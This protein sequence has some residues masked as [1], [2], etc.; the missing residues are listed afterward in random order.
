MLLA[1]R[2]MHTGQVLHAYGRGW[3][4][5]PRNVRQL[6]VLVLLVSFYFLLLLPLALLLSALLGCSS[7][8]VANWCSG[9]ANVF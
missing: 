7:T 8:I 4:F 6:L 9:G 1:I 5:D 2:G 3:A